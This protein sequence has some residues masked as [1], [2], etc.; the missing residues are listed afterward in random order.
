MD[1][2]SAFL[3]CLCVS[4]VSVV[5][6]YALIFLV[7]Q[8][9]KELLAGRNLINICIVCT[10][11]KNRDVVSFVIVTLCGWLGYIA[12]YR[13]TIDVSLSHRTINQAPCVITCF[14]VRL[15]DDYTIKQL[16]SSSPHTIHNAIYITSKLTVCQNTKSLNTPV[17]ATDAW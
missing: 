5:Q 3:F 11:Y 9:G 7:L 14:S 17:A 16:S 10:A 15:K 12:S 8:I 4:V 6:Q 13:R 2:N 1:N